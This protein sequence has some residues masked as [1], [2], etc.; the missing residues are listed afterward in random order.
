MMNEYCAD[1][2]RASRYIYQAAK[3]NETYHTT[4]DIWIWR[5]SRYFCFWYCA[6]TSTFFR[7]TYC[8]R[9]GDYR[10]SVSRRLQLREYDDSFIIGT[11]AMNW[12]T[13]DTRM[14][15]WLQR[16][17]RE[18]RTNSYNSVNH[19]DGGFR[20]DSR[21]IADTIYSDERDVISKTYRRVWCDR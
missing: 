12:S 3:L 21:C 19:C 5:G 17:S 16:S 10:L 6:K 14:T 1:W 11:W 13:H 4:Q 2:F 9:K 20:S 7:S 15:K 18:A 8:L